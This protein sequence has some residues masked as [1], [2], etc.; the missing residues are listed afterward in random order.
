VRDCTEDQRRIMRRA[1]SMGRQAMLRRQRA[2]PL[3][4]AYRFIVGCGSRS[5]EEVLDSRTHKLIA[6]HV[7]ASLMSGRTTSDD[8]TVVREVLRAMREA[9]WYGASLAQRVGA[10][11][12]IL[13]DH[14]PDREC[15]EAWLSAHGTL[16]EGL[17]RKS[18]RM[19]LPPCC[20]GSFFEPVPV[21]D[22]KSEA[23]ATGEGHGD[24]LR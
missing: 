6:D 3:V 11:R 8:E 15:C 1:I 14:V 19:I 21:E 23:Q 20:D 4:F 5:P 17:F 22:V 18:D 7:I 13:P 9:Q 16:A 12:C 24:P 10:F 2:E